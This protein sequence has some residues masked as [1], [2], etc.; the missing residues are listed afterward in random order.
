M[1]DVAAKAN[2]PLEGRPTAGRTSTAI[3]ARGHA[4]APFFAEIVG[5]PKGTQAPRALF[6]A[7]AS[8]ANFAVSAQTSQKA[9]A[10]ETAEKSPIWGLCM[11]ASEEGHASAD[12]IA[13]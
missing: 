1:A 10:P 3:A 11:A 13:T 4:L 9:W 2:W 6:M 8:Q 7:A 5:V 12:G